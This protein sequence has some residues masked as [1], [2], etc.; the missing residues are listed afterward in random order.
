MGDEVSTILQALVEELMGC[1]WEE[2]YILLHI[3]EGRR[4]E[5]SVIP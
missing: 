4:E 1:K 5:V 3:R 2:L